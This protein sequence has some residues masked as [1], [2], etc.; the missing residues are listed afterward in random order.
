V[1][2]R[3]HLKA[4]GRNKKTKALFIKSLTKEISQNDAHNLKSLYR[5]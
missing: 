2:K 3:R 4:T 1:A 5:S